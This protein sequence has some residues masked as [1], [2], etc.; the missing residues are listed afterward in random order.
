MITPENVVGAQALFKVAGMSQPI[1]LTEAEQTAQVRLWLRI[2]E[3]EGTTAE[4]FRVGCE[5]CIKKDTFFPTIGRI[6]TLIEEARE[7]GRASAPRGSP[8]IEAAPV[9]RASPEQIMEA[10]RKIQGMAAP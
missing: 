2:L 8:L 5:A 9:E 7:E 10:F 4:E 3:E 6:L 1:T